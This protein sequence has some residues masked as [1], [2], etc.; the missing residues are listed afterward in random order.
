MTITID[1]SPNISITDELLPGYLTKVN[2]TVDKVRSF[3][4]ENATYTEWR[5]NDSSTMEAVKNTTIW[6]EEAT[7]SASVDRGLPLHI[8]REVDHLISLGCNIIFEDGMLNEFSICLERLVLQY[9]SVL[10]DH[11]N[12][13]LESNQIDEGVAYEMLRSLGEMEHIP[14][15]GNRLYMLIDALKSTTAKVRDGAAL[16]LALMDEPLAI[17]ELKKAIHQEKISDLRDD[18]KLVLDQ[19]E[20]N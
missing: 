18:M 13:R 11:L 15:Y 7:T 5:V 17:P 4:Y 19:L 6:S 8:V 3:L 1:Y 14:S 16:G 10:L 12:Q 2:Q 20:E 9:G